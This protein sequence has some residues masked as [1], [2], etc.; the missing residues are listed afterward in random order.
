MQL[1]PIT[2]SFSRS[3]KDLEATYSDD[4]I[5]QR[6]IFFQV[7]LLIGVLFYG[8]FGIM[9]ALFMPQQKHTLWLIRMVCIFHSLVS[10]LI[11]TYSL[12]VRSY[13]QLI[14]FFFI[15]SAS[16]CIILMCMIAPPPFSYYYY[17]GLILVLIFLY[18]NICLRFILAFLLGWL[19]VI[20]YNVGAYLSQVPVQEIISNNFF[21]ISANILGSI[22]CYFTE[23]ISRKN[24]YLTHLLSRKQSELLEMS[25]AAGM[26][27]VATGVLHNVGNVLN[28]VNVSCSLIQDQLRQSRVGNVGRVAEMLAQPEGGLGRFLTEDPRGQK[29]PAYLTTLAGALQEEQALLFREAGALQSRIEH[30]KEIVSMQQSYG[31]VS[32]VRETLHP[33]QLLEDALKL[34]A[35]ALALRGVAVR[36]EYETVPQII[37]DKHK[38]LQILLNLINNAKSACTSDD[39]AERIVTLGLSQPGPDRVLFQ[40]TDNGM[41]IAPENLTRIF[42]HGFTTRKDGHG[43][44]LHSGALAARELGGSLTVHSDGPDKG[45][46]FSLELPTGRDTIS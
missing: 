26:A 42:Q 36:R 23:F 24:F 22:M 11:V 35:E 10:F 17:A 27:E 34:N 40:V 19:I 39:N 15:F 9:D 6:L 28:S 3:M 2:L 44:G 46:T 13:M 18:S 30:I 32:G 31:R 25:R 4:F 12:R 8:L 37:V 16:L 20:M 5:K 33:E 45:A 21:L 1:N 7:S 14:S 29:I 41:G 38:V 43:F